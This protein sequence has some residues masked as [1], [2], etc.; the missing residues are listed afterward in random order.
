MYRNG[1]PLHRQVMAQCPSSN[2]DASVAVCGP[3]ALRCLQL[4]R[5]HGPFFMQEVR[6]Q[7][8]VRA[9]GAAGW[10]ARR[11]LLGANTFPFAIAVPAAVAI[12]H[13][14][15]RSDGKSSHAGGTDQRTVR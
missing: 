7:I 3:E 4:F 13:A 8:F 5:K 15:D 6:L 12:A 10:F 1:A 9:S 11:V 14:G 2:R